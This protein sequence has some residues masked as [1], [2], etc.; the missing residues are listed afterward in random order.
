[1]LII[2]YFTYSS[3]QTM[4]K[5]TIIIRTI[6]MIGSFLGT[7]FV[8]S[9]IFSQPEDTTDQM[10]RNI[11]KRHLD[12]RKTKP[13]IINEKLGVSLESK[14]YPDLKKCQNK[15]SKTFFTLKGEFWILENYIQ[16]TKTFKCNESITYTTHSEFQ[17]LENLETLSDRWQVR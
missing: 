13:P 5:Q 2:K 4:L 10:I 9:H 11:L 7:A 16:A 8:T 15:N 17:F 12:I 14:I 1:M 6:V 3:P